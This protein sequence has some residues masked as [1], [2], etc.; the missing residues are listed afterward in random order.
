MRRRCRWRGGRARRPTP[1]RMEGLRQHGCSA[2][3]HRRQHGGRRAQV[4]QGHG[5]PHHLAGTEFPGRSDRRGHRKQ[6]VPGRGN[7]FG[8][9]GSARREEQGPQLVGPRGVVGPVATPGER[10][11][12]RIILHQNVS[13]RIQLAGNLLDARPSLGVG[14]HHFGPGHPEVVQQKVTLVR[15]VHGRAQRADSRL[16]Q[17]EVDPLRA[18]RRVQR[19]AVAGA[20]SQFGQHARRRAGPLPHLLESHVGA[21]DRH[22]HTVRVLLGATIQHRGNGKTVDAEIG[23]TRGPAH[24]AASQ[25]LAAAGSG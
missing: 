14:D 9:P 8:R 23:G 3:Q 12:Q 7:R 13:R 18:R 25:A 5:G 6:V 21:G 2:D 11:A 17:P 4:E 22:H 20:D 24:W 10:A 19:H 1:R 15:G 16:A